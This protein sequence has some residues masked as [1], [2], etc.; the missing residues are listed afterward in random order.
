MDLLEIKEKH[1]MRREE[2][3][4]LLHQIAD[5]LGRQNS[6]H[7]TKEGL[8]FVVDVA[9]QVEVEVELEV[10]DEGNSLEIEI[11]W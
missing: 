4:K 6:L 10:S 2:A 8:K 7:F 3:A 5:A 11:N 1:S 9:D